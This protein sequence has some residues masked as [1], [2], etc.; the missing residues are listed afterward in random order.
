MIKDAIANLPNSW[1]LRADVPCRHGILLPLRRSFGVVDVNVL[2]RNLSDIAHPVPDTDSSPYYDY[3]NAALYVGDDNGSL[4]K[5]QPVFTTGAPAEVGSPW[6]VALTPG[7]I[8]SSP[9]FDA[10]SGRVFVGRSYNG[11]TGSRLYAVTKGSSCSTL[12]LGSLFQLL[13]VQ[14]RPR[15]D[16]HMTPR[17]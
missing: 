15:G 1:E 7:L 11:T 14:P 12:L 3:A 2:Y 6:P 4:H 5:L 17:Q 13:K 10:A 8:L 9:V 16:S